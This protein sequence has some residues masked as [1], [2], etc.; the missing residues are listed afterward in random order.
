MEPRPIFLFVVLSAAFF[1][2]LKCAH[3][4]KYRAGLADG[5][6][7]GDPRRAPDGGGVAE[8]NVWE[9]GVLTSSF[10]L[11]RHRADESGERR[12]LFLRQRLGGLIVDYQTERYFLLENFFSTAF[13]RGSIGAISISLSLFLVSEF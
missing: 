4:P 13:V 8:K 2:S 9:V 12:G 6:E 5:W 10:F 1:S 7:L 11:T 3:D